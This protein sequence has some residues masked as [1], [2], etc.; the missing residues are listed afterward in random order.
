M[1]LLT[2]LFALFVA[3]LC[4]CSSQPAYEGPEPED[5]GVAQEALGTCTQPTGSA[6]SQVLPI[7]EYVTGI[8]VGAHP[9][10]IDVETTDIS[11]GAKVVGTSTFG[12]GQAKIAG[13]GWSGTRITQAVL[14]ASAAWCDANLHMVCIKLRGSG[15]VDGLLK[16]DDAF[17]AQLAAD[18]GT[19]N[20]GV[21]IVKVRGYGL[22]QAQTLRFYNGLSDGTLFSRQWRFEGPALDACTDPG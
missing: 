17:G 4:G 7:S 9:Y 1:K 14:G 15:G 21:G 5:V 20:L 18:W 13:S 16:F 3:A 22:V 8:H 6:G 12:V 11:T 10:E 19:Y 2:V